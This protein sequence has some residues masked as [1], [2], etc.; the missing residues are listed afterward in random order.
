MAVIVRHASRV[1]APRGGYRLGMARPTWSG[2]ISFGLVNV[3]VKAY[4]AVHEHTVHFHQLD[5][6]TGARV[7]YK[8]VSEKSGRTLEAD[9]IEKGYEITKGNY[10]VVDDDEFEELRPASTKTIDVTDFVDLSAIDPIYYAN[11]YWLGT[12]ESGAKAYRLLL[13]AM[14][15]E[16][17]VGVGT[18]VMRNKQYLAAIRPLDGA[19]AMSTMRFADEVVPREEI[20]AVPTR[21]SK[22]S[23]GEL[24]LATQIVESLTTDWDPSRYRDDYTEQLEHL[25]KDK[26]KGKQVTVEPA[27]EQEAKVLDLMEALRASVEEHKGRRSAGTTGSKRPAKKPV[28]KRSTAKK[29]SAKKASAK[30]PAARRKSA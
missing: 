14:E 1:V 10:V 2:S 17:R 18:V 7:K 20:D 25:I 30:K 8:K 27:A 6:K 24:K 4:T 12:D 28:A 5:K 13:A 11:T 22:P 21:G 3:P 23:A 29:A 26:A 9:D 19:L 15:K 16:Q